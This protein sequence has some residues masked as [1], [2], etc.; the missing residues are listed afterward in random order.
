MSLASASLLAHRLKHLMINLGR[1]NLA[2]ILL[3]FI[4]Q[5]ITHLVADI[6]REFSLGGLTPSALGFTNSA[7]FK[8]S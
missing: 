7:S 3:V 4:N 2:Q 6:G 5:F 1:E 8:I